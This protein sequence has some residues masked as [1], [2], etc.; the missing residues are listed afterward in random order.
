MDVKRMIGGAG[1]RQDTG[2]AVFICSSDSRRDVLDRML[3]A[4]QKFWPD[5]PWPVYVGLNAGD[6]PLLLGS[7]ILAR[8]SEW[9]RE[10]WIELA[11]LSESHL[12]LLLDDFLFEAPVD[13][14]RL[15]NL[16]EDAERLN[17]DYLRL[18]PLGRSLAARLAGRTPS[19]LSA[20][21]E[22]IS[23]QH[24]FY[25]G[26]QVA[27]WRKAYLRRLVEDPLSIWAFERRYVPGSVHGAITGTPPIAYHHMVE[28]G[29]WL[30]DAASRFRRAGLPVSLG[31]RPVWSRARY[32]NLGLE[33]MRW[34]LLGYSNC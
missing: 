9:H 6:P 30:P 13:Q 11:Q 4:V 19:L 22:Q 23:R 33:R 1:K 26:M 12:L 2:V 5:C 16:V 25:C 20:G 15:S 7:P 21:I 8:P 27:I 10:C 24:P 29:R 32:V 17:L 14:R 28:R 3:P 18:V 34:F 31:E